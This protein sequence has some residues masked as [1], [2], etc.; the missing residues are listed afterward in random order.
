MKI[1]Y[2]EMFCFDET[3]SAVGIF[4]FD[5]VILVLSQPISIQG[6]EPYLGDFVRKMCMMLC[7]QTFVNQFLPNLDITEHTH[8]MLFRM[9]VTYI[10]K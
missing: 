6:R 8:L 9:M 3:W 7:L 10:T 4:W 1:S 5:D 2:L